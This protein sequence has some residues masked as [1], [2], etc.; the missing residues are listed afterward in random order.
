MT[1]AT[2]DVGQSPLREILASIDLGPTGGIQFT[3][4]KLMLAQAMICKSSAESYMKQ[5]EEIQ[6]LQTKTADMISKARELKQEA[7]DGGKGHCTT[8][9]DDMVKFFQDNGLAEQSTGGD[10]LHQDFEWDYNL[11]SLTNFQ[12]TIGNKTQTL[13]V[14]L[15]DF[16]SQ[17]NSN[18]QGANSAIQ[19]ASQVLTSIATGR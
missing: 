9:P 8:M 1:T 2:N 19:N 7:T 18:L 17:Y 15:Q 13:M 12:E 10:H 6:D 3:F 4:A 16:M 5:I 14:Y 11:E